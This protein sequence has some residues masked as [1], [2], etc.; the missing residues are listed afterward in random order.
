MR[1]S[2]ARTL[3]AG[4]QAHDVSQA[5]RSCLELK[6]LVCSCTEMRLSASDM[7]SASPPCSSALQIE[8]TQVCKNTLNPVWNERLWLLVQVRYACGFLVWSSLV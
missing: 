5:C 4:R 1:G 3:V 2:L 8:R 7:P 6:L